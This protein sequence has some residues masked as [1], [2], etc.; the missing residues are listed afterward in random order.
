MKKIIAAVISI[1]ILISCGETKENNNDTQNVNFKNHI[2]DVKK[3]TGPL[4]K[5]RYKFK[6]GDKFSY[7]L[8]TIAN[9]TE[10]IVA[11]TTLTNEIFQ[12][13]TY[14]MDFVVKNISED[15]TTELETR[16]TK[17]TAET[18]FN[19]ETVKYDSKFIYSTR[20]R[21]Q[22]VDYEAV[23]K[24][25]FKIFVNQFGQVVKVDN[26]K[27]IMK[28]ILEIQQVPDTLSNATKEKM[29]LNI[30]NGTLMPLT[31]QVF[32]VVS[33]DTVGKDS[34]WILKYSTPL[35]VFKV[36][37]TALF[38]ISEINFVE[39]DTLV[40][41][42]SNLSIS[43]TGQNQ[44][45]EKG[46]TYNFSEPKLSGSGTVIFNSSLGLVQKS[47]SNT[48]LEMAMLAEGFDANNQR[49]QSTKKD[50]SNNTNVVELL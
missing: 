24:V 25:P 13:S 6:K 43:W 20:E 21:A 28:N 47:E 16:I 40:N 42:A 34:T 48:K 9:N 22:F 10:E 26:I 44:V 33:E 32:K 36:D 14:K 3:E 23:K 38:R 5:L 11:D 37:N 17:I 50:F 27:K 35:A 12:T 49:L 45:S 46:V 31:Q 4:I 1:A 2:A 8:K 39:N 30:A 15:Q 29:E 19:G 7:K 41:I 18:I